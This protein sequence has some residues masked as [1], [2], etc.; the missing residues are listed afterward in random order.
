MRLKKDSALQTIQQ[1]W[2]GDAV[3]YT[4]LGAGLDLT[5]IPQDPQK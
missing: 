3:E 2:K 4:N 1:S 5:L